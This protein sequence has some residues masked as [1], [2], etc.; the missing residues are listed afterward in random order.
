MISSAIVDSGPLLAATNL[1]DPDHAACVELLSDPA[2]RLV[3]P[4]LCITEVSFLLGR[5]QGAAVEAQF[6]RGL[7]SFGVRGPR[8]DDWPR[9]AAL[10]ERYADFPLGSV[11]ASVAVLA[12]RLET[13][14]ILTLDRRH[15][16]AL[17]TP[18]GGRY[19]LL[20]E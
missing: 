1:A 9:I 4:A 6:L 20:P 7:E 14:L 16:S 3:I 10:V 5:R 15:F 19:R 12:D 17:T 8:S 11:D 2:L 18:S 13:D